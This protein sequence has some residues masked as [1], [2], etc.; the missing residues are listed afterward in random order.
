MFGGEASHSKKLCLSG[1]YVLPKNE[2]ND[3]RSVAIPMKKEKGDD[4]QKNLHS[5]SNSILLQYLFYFFF[6]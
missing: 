3:E 6:L 4:D 1:V 5:K 2:M